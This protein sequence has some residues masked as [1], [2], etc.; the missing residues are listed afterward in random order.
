MSYWISLIRRLV[1]RTAISPEISQLNTSAWVCISWL[2]WS[3]SDNNDVWEVTGVRADSGWSKAG[4]EGLP[5]SNAGWLDLVN[6]DDLLVAVHGCRQSHSQAG[7][8]RLGHFHQ[9]RTRSTGYG[10]CVEGSVERTNSKWTSGIEV[11]QI[12]GDNVSQSLTPSGSQQTAFLFHKML[13]RSLHLL[14]S[15]LE[16]MTRKSRFH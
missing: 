13:H 2:C 3:G 12:K 16:C 6:D 8:Q 15:S 14:Q 5:V 11:I 7:A 4:T 1:L 10:V 9:E